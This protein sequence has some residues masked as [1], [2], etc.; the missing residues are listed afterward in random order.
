[1]VVRRAHVE[2]FMTANPEARATINRIA[3]ARRVMNTA[4][5]AN[6]SEAPVPE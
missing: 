6:S 2:R 5:R 4:D 1:V 3:E